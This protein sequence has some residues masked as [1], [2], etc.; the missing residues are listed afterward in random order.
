MIDIY[1]NLSVTESVD[2]C[3]F[4][5]ALVYGGIL[6]NVDTTDQSL[7]IGYVFSDSTKYPGD[8][9]FYQGQFLSSEG[10]TLT[11]IDRT[12]TGGFWNGTTYTDST[13]WRKDRYFDP[14]W[15]NYSIWQ[16]PSN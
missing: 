14:I 4:T 5:G 13:L 7:F 15:I 1:G 9:T 3:L 2:T 12:Y 16:L 11:L 10:L 6:S 8:S